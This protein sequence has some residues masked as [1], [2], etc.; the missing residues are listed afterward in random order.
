MN[1]TL[2]VKEIGV[3]VTQ[4]FAFCLHVL[5]SWRLDSLFASTCQIGFSFLVATLLSRD[6]R[7]PH[8][9]VRIRAPTQGTG[10]LATSAPRANGPALAEAMLAMPQNSLV[11]LHSSAS[12]LGLQIRAK[13]GFCSYRLS[14]FCCSFFVGRL[15]HLVSSR[16]PTSSR[17]RCRL[18]S[19]LGFHPFFFNDRLV[20]PAEIISQIQRDPRTLAVITS[21]AGKR[22]PPGV[23]NTHQPSTPSSHSWRR[24]F[25]NPVR[26]TCQRAHGDGANTG[27][28]ERTAMRPHRAI[29]LT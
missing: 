27:G 11:R 10:G 19:S 14:F 18:R 6:R 24:G 20:A 13:S 8:P 7:R 26:W 2:V 15:I 22:G 21:A 16:V 9:N 23:S 25:A 4:P 28:N 29:A 1:G 12:L 5:F 17:R 3:C